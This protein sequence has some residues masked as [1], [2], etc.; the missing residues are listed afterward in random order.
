MTALAPPPQRTDSPSAATSWVRHG[1]VQRSGVW[2]ALA[3]VIAFNVMATPRFLTL[4]TLQTNLTQ[5]AAVAVVAFGMTLIIATGGIDL[6]VGSLMALSGAGAGVLLL[7]GLPWISGSGGV[8]V[9]ILTGLA[10]ATLFGLVN[11]FLVATLRIQPIVAT[12]VVLITGR[13]IAQLATSGRLFTVESR[14][15]LWLGRGTLLGISV[16]AWLM[17]AVLVVMVWIARSTVLGRYIVAVGGNERAA[18]LAGVPVSAVKYTV[19]GIGGLLAG[20]AGLLS[21]GING[22]VDTANLGLGWEFLVISAVVVGGTSLTGG[23]PRLGGTLGGV[24]LL[25]LL[26]FTLASHNIPRETANLIQAAVIIM[27]VAFQIR[28]R[29]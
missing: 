1:G 22:T 18:R 6:S 17:L 10:V 12:L 29:R 4:Q 3:V 14:E 9:I 13:G 21:I 28:A 27:A 24:A 11:G 19:Y 25:Q 8:I 23:R 16:Q 5:M 2:I 20:L 7:S 15:I 26:A